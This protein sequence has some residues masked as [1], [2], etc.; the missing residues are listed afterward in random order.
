MTSP[1]WKGDLSHLGI[2][3]LDALFDAAR[4]HARGRGPAHVD[5][6]VY[7]AHLLAFLHARA[8][9]VWVDFRALLR[10]RKVQAGGVYPRQWL[11]TDHCALNGTYADEDAALAAALRASADD[12]PPEECCPIDLLPFADPV[13]TIHGTKYSRKNIQDWFDRGNVTDPLTGCRL[14]TTTLYDATGW[15]AV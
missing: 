14:P 2:R 7:K 11:R 1:Y 9:D 15:T 6:A 4:A 13:A 8:P 5:G 12:A 10:D 3:S